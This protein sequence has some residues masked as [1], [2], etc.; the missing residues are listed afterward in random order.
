MSIAV[1][2]SEAPSVG[3]RDDLIAAIK[4][5]QNR[6]DVADNS[7]KRHLQ[8]VEAELNRRLRV[9]DM[10]MV[11]S[12]Q[13][14]DGAVSLPDEFLA[15]RAVYDADKCIIPAVDPMQLIETPAYGEKVYSLIGG[16]LRVAPDSDELVTCIYYRTIPRLIADSPTNW[17]LDRHA[18]IYLHGVNAHF[19]NYVQDTATAAREFQLFDRAIDQLMMAS[20][21]DRYGGPLRQRGTMRQTRGPRA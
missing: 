5:E 18:D 11:A 12:L 16:Q 17:L 1:T 6:D 4:D 8:L 10:E 15:M 2:L 19:A 14:A 3:S 7:V 9:P 13:M 21:H 20:L